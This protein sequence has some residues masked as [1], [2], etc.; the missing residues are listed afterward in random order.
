ML[1]AK[2]QLEKTP[3]RFVPNE[4]VEYGG[5]LFLLPSLLSTGLLSYQ[6]HYDKLSGYYD[7]DTIILSLAF[8]Y[9]CRIKNPEQLKH[10]SPGEF[11]KLLGIDRIPE[12][13]N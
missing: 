4:G 11:G 12:A 2:G 1:A 5:V 6:N 8:M 13:K 9:L 10:I 3:I 7:L